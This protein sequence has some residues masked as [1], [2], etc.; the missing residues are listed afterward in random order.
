MFVVAFF[1]YF[2]LYQPQNKIQQTSNFNHT[3]G[4]IWLK[5]NI[6]V[7]LMVDCLMCSGIYSILI[8]DENKLYKLCRNEIGIGQT[9]HLLLTAT[10]KS[11]ESLSELRLYY[12]FSFFK[13]TKG[14]RQRA[15][16]LRTWRHP[17]WSM[18]RISSS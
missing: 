1:T 14:F 13:F 4:F 16:T 3:V 5:I 7:W 17:L 10:E 15:W 11:M 6:G 2:F 9:G 12:T 18:A 8:Y